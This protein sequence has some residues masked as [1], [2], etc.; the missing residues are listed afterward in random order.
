MQAAVRDIGAELNK[1]DEPGVA[2]KEGLFAL[3]PLETVI[4]DASHIL[5]HPDNGLDLVLLAKESGFHRDI[6]QKEVDTDGPGSGSGSENQEHG[7]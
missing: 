7:L 1:D 4:L 3:A 5:L 2:V 6:W